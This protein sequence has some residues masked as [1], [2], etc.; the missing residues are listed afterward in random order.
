MSPLADAYHAKTLEMLA[1]ARE[2]NAAVIA[3][4]APVLGASIAA[5]GM[6]H[7]FGSG[8]SEII[9]REIVGRAGGLVCI[10]SINDPTAGFIENQIGRA[11][12]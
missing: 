9:A 11:H 3:R 8:H 2:R 7:T 5:G 10:T 1:L 4:L 12:V 6:V